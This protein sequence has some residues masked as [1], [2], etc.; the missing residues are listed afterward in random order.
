MAF[1]VLPFIYPKVSTRASDP[2][3]RERISQIDHVYYIN[4]DERPDRRAEVLVEL[5]K[6]GFPS[7]Q[8]TRVPGVKHE[9]GAIGCARSHVLALDL[10]LSAGH[11]TFMI[12]ED[13]FQMSQNVSDPAKNLWNFFELELEW[14]CLLVA[15]YTKRF[16][17][18]NFDT[19]VR[20]LES[21][22]TC[23]YVL[24][25]EYA[26]KV[27]SIFQAADRNLTR[28]PD[29]PGQAIDQAWK[30]LQ[31]EGRWFVVT[32]V[33]AHQRDGWSTIEQRFVSYPDK[34]ELSRD[35]RVHTSL[36]VDPTAS[37]GVPE[38]C[39][40]YGLR[41]MPPGNPEFAI[42]EVAKELRVVL[43]GRHST[44]SCVFLAA[45]RATDRLIS[46]SGQFRQVET[47]FISGLRFTR[48]QLARALSMDFPER[49]TM[50]E[51][52]LLLH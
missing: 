9:R 39:P 52:E 20:A 4:L 40:V 49:A 41:V 42:D 44:P 32:P 22:T 27:R 16:E 29:K 31:P 36:V 25:P 23:A 47:I 51:I 2:P 15:A 45:L 46:S 18:T 50:E 37:S 24:R 7:E 38:P 12:V 21:Q 10:A 11:S 1:A 43:R 13:D 14:D 30:V 28:D 26:R 48:E 33:V 8:I 3:R 17:E 19:V 5:D 6:L 35:R 34:V